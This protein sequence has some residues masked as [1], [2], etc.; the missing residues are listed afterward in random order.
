LPDLSDEE[1]F[2]PSSRFCKE[3]FAS[4]SILYQQLQGDIFS[5]CILHLCHHAR[6]PNGTN[7]QISQTFQYLINFKMPYNIPC[8]H[9]P[10]CYLSILSD[11]VIDFAFVS[12]GR[13]I[14]RP[15]TTGDDRRCLCSLLSM[16]YPISAPPTIHAGVSVCILKS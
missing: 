8:C 2:C 7:F 11:V 15:T 3:F 6:K 13:G 14:W 12:V 9:F 5:L 10:Q 16:I 1:S 4:N